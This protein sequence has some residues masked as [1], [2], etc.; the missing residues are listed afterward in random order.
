MRKGKI[1]LI[2]GPGGLPGA[3]YEIG[4]LMALEDFI[5]QDI[6][7][8]V[9]DFQGSSCGAII[10]FALMSNFSTRSLYSVLYPDNPYY[11][12]MSDL[13]TLNLAEIA[14]AAAVLPYHLAKILARL[15]TTNDLRL[16][17]RL[18]V[19]IQ[20]TPLSGLFVTDGIQAYVERIIKEFRL[21]PRFADFCRHAGKNLYL[22]T[23]D[24]STGEPLILDPKRFGSLEVKKAIAASATV[25]PLFKPVEV[26]NGDG[27]RH[28]LA[29]GA[30]AMSLGIRHAYERGDGLILYFNPLRPTTVNGNVRN[31]FD[32]S[33]QLY[34]IPAHTR[35]TVAEKDH[36]AHHPGTL[37]GF[38]PDTNTMFHNLFRAD[39]RLEYADH[40]YASTLHKLHREYPRV[41]RM[42]QRWG[43]SVI[44]RRRLS[45]LSAGFHPGETLAARRLPWPQE[46]NWLRRLFNHSLGV[47]ESLLPGPPDRGQA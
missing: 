21:P 5:E 40:G 32:I 43:L 35:K 41:K 12:K 38:E 11:F 14:Q 17:E 39:L 4:G 3:A 19:P 18:T 46:S 10:A 37:F 44:S 36:T 16:Y 9:D 34:R 20:N 22:L 27:T 26:E 42:F 2:L 13:Y 28:K 7:A 8:V 1:T 6:F 23:T 31:V 30:F 47:L 33:E 25:A 15:V 29:D 24:L 45:A